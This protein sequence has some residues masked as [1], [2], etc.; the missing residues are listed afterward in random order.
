[1]NVLTIFQ[2]DYESLELFNNELTFFCEKNKNLKFNSAET[3]KIK[4]CINRVFNKDFNDNASSNFKNTKKSYVETFKTALLLSDLNSEGNSLQEESTKI[5]DYA[6]KIEITNHRVVKKELVKFIVD[7]RIFHRI[8][9]INT[10]LD[11][12]EFKLL[13]PFSANIESINAY[14]RVK[15]GDL[16]HIA[17]M[18]L[19]VFKLNNGVWFDG[20]GLHHLQNMTSLTF[21]DLYGCQSI[22]N[23]HLS[24]LKGM[25]QLTHLDL[26]ATGIS[27]DDLKYLSSM[28][29]LV[30]LNLCNTDKILGDG[31]YSLKSLQNLSELNLCSVKFSF[32]GFQGLNE[33][34]ITSLHLKSLSRGLNSLIENRD[35]MKSLKKMPLKSLNIKFWNLNSKG[36]KYIKNCPLTELVLSSRNINDDCLKI[37]GKLPLIKLDLYGCDIT[38][39]GLAH[40]SNVAQSSLKEL[41]LECCNKVT[42]EGLNFICGPN[43]VNL[44]L[45]DGCVMNDAG[46]KIIS[47]CKSL[48]KLT[49]ESGTI[50][51]LGVKE[52]LR[53]LPLELL[54]I[55]QF[56]PKIPQGELP[57]WKELFPGTTLVF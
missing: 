53:G 6:E 26:S 2:K 29:K 27:D 15:D 17:A 23:S 32:L 39:M 48:N 14:Y 44:N 10:E 57:E 49:I 19:Q 16:K 24:N 31:L 12:E 7:N 54:F 51:L 18:P 50:T 41:N 3:L 30:Y 55:H 46:L 21:L 25:T 1:M 20:S 52:N 13:E 8:S 5:I 28:T 37:L 38:D 42:N 33:L 9:N 22:V 34:P 45:Q 36:L 43:I 35:L 47:K 4:E 56:K 40:I 11:V